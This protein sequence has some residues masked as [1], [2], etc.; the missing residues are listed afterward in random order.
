MDYVTDIEIAEL[1]WAE[2]MAKE[3]KAL[4]IRVKTRIRVRRYRANLRARN[5]Q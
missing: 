3:A 4:R 2:A 5:E 1:E